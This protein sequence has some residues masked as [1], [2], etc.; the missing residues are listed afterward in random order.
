MSKIVISGLVSNSLG[1]RSKTNLDTISGVDIGLVLQLGDVYSFYFNNEISVIKIIEIIDNDNVK[2]KWITPRLKDGSIP[3][4]PYGYTF[5]SLWRGPEC[6][7]NNSGNYETAELRNGFFQIDDIIF[8]LL[9]EQISNWDWTQNNHLSRWKEHLGSNIPLHYK[10]RRPIL[11]DDY[12]EKDLGSTESHNLDKRRHPYLVMDVL[13][14]LSRFQDFPW[15]ETWQKLVPNIL[16]ESNL[17]GDIEIEF[18]DLEIYQSPKVYEFVYQLT[19]VAESWKDIRILQTH[20][21]NEIFPEDM[22]ERWV[23]F[24]SGFKQRIKIEEPSIINPFEDRGIFECIMEI[25][26]ELPLVPRCPELTHKFLSLNVNIND[27]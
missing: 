25:S 8:D 7:L 20:M 4:P 23:T 18:A 3:F 19:G 16:L 15:I 11:R 12:V 2:V 9:E 21:E 13:P 26:V 10:H 5:T 14:Y 6:G 22:G 27:F 24:P 1:L 17:E